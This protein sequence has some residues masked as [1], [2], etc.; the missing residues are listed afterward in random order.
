MGNAVE[1]LMGMAIGWE[2]FSGNGKTT[3]ASKML[4]FV[5]VKIPVTLNDTACQMCLTYFIDSH[6]LKSNKLDIV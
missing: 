5:P 6:L 1:L 4:F 3:F 2:N